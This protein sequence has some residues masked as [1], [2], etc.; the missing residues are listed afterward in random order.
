MYGLE[1]Q[2]WS[3]VTQS[4]KHPTLA[5]VMISLFRELKPR[6]RLHADSVEPTW[7]ILSLPLPLSLCPLWD[8]LSL[9]LP[10][11]LA[12]SPSQKTE[13]KTKQKIFLGN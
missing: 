7:D 8:S 1:D 6:C 11:S 3:W 4:V 2:G 12:P 9:P 10:H 5:Q 13:N